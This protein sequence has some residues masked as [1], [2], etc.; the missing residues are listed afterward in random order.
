MA[1]APALS[2]GVIEVKLDDDQDPKLRDCGICF[3]KIDDAE[4]SEC[5]MCKALFCA[6]CMRSYIESKVQDGLV[7]SQ[8]MICPAPECSLALSEELLTAF[9]DE[10]TFV[11]YKAFLLNQT[12]GIRFCPR[13]GCCA[14]LE[15]PL[16][17]HHRRVKC[18][19]CREES[20]MRC[21]RAFHNIPVCRSLEKQLR[22]WKKQQYKN[23]RSCPRCLVII[24]KN[25]GCTHMTCTHCQ[26]QFCWVCSAKWETHCKPWCN[27]RAFVRADPHHS[28]P[29]RVVITTAKCGATFAVLVVGATVVS[30]V[31]L[32]ALPPLVVCAMLKKNDDDD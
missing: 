12:V 2:V 29:V 16:N 1:M 21:G 3:E 22:K 4:T 9:T 8:A 28:T 31:F 23:V 19:T 7:S 17:S 10:S 14:V 25:G 26:H 30:S 20:C 6:K 24:E 32:A 5:V 13:V 18:P 15:E 11:K 27:L